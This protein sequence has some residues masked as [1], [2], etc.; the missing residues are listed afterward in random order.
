MSKQLR[1]SMLLLLTAFIWGVAFVAQSEGGDAVG[2]YT[3]N[4]VRSIIGGFVLIP[5]IF[6][7]EKI[8]SRGNK[9][10]N[11]E[12]KPKE[13]KK[14]LI[15]GGILCGI[16]LFMGS[17]LQQLGLYYGTTAG[18]AG[19][20]T[21]CYIL[22]VPILGLFLKKK[23]G[24]NI[25]I[26]VFLSLIGLYLLCI[27]ESFSLAFGDI[28]VLC[29]AMAFSIHILLVDY[30]SPRVSGV[31]MS[32]IQF[33]TCGIIGI[34]PTVFVEMG[35]S[36]ADISSWI[37]A[38]GTMSAWVP[39]LYAGVLSCGVAYTL[40]IIGQDGL[41]PTIAS[42][43]MSLESVFA[44]LAGWIILGQNMSLKEVSGCVLIFMAIILAQLPI[45]KVMLFKH[46]KI[47]L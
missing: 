29:S 37:T 42:L 47:K 28:L 7:I 21:A 9:S 26:G 11:V 8:T 20:L 41:N 33:F 45:D 30:F 18:K 36:T 46:K 4:C 16:A 40:Q 27:D 31:K 6:I 5:V 44:V 19:F 13:N 2:P 15:L 38:L 43:L 14:V 35:T 39:I 22:L 24:F 17:T 3:F 10:K 23:C 25:W 34:V 1:N 32:C 12:N